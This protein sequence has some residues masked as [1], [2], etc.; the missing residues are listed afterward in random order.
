M[1]AHL[2]RP[3]LHTAHLLTFAVVFATGVLMLAPGLRAALVGGYSLLLREAHRWGGVAFAALPLAIIVSFGPRTLFAPPANRTAR[4][5]WQGLHVVLT[6][7]MVVVFTVTGFILWG[8]R[9]F[10]ETIVQGSVSAHEWLTYFAAAAVVI[11]LV[12]IGLAA[13]MARLAAPAD[14]QQS[15][16]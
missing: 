3:L 7:L 11:H 14:A 15:Q 13:L 1:P 6:V 9:T 16:T 12:D 10:P 8:K 2:A 4:S 5:L